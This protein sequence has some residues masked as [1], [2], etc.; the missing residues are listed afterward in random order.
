MRIRRFFTITLV[1]AAFI[2]AQSFGASVRAQAT[3][4]YE[5]RVVTAVEVVIEG[6]PRDEAAEAEMLSALHVAAGTPYTAVRVR[7]S[8]EALFDSGL[9][10]NARV[11]ASETCRPAPDAS[12]SRPLC[13]RFIVRRQVKVGEVRLS[14]NLPL[15]S[16]ISEDEIRAR[17]NMLETGSNLSE[18]VLKNNADLIQAYLRDKGFNRAEVTYA[19]VRDPSDPT[20][21][22][23]T[24]VFSINTGE[25]A[26][27]DAFDIKI[28]G[29]DVQS[30]RPKLK[31][32]AGAPFSR[33]AL[34]DDINTIR[35]AIIKTGHLAPH[36][37]DPHVTV[38]NN[39]VKIELDGGIG[40]LVTV[41]ILHYAIS[42]KT[43]RTL[44]PIKREGNIDLSAIEEG[45][46]RLTNKLQENG[47]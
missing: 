43:Q 32:Q 1:L 10:S 13:V 30:V 15:N 31:L 11:E 7:E 12:A 47:Y 36:L 33:A 18:T 37:E 28:T 29:F 16:P 45:K 24:V 20:G 23:Q 27:V 39:Q 21:A 6:T 14:L 25:Q 46:R 19:Q 2:A 40:P 17:L 38:E 9:V 26:R 42:S 3:G 44:L 34:G 41:D 8:L 22:R 4:D 35:Q 5:G